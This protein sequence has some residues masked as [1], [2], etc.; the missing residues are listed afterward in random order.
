MIQKIVAL[1]KKYF[2]LK[3]KEAKIYINDGRAFLKSKAAKKYNLIMVDAYRDITI[4]FHMTTKEFFLQ[5]KKHLN[6]GGVLI[7]NINMH[8]EKNTEITDYLTQ[9]VKSVM[10]RVYKCD[11]INGTNTLVF[12]SDD[13]NCLQNFRK[14]IVSIPESNPLFSITRFVDSNLSEVIES[15]HILTDEVAPV[16]LMGQKVLDEIV[17]K[18]LIYFKNQLKTSKNGI[19]DIFNLIGN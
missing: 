11:M 18:E 3:D 17:G 13:E 16:E 5:V 7:I 12:S 19:W 4:P 1:S 9:T 10:N 15:T 8:S 14:N 6:P 2:D